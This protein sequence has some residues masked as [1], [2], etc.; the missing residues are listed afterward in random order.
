M[1]AHGGL[2][3]PK[4]FDEVARTS[5]FGGCDHRQQSEARRVG[6]D[7][8]PAGEDRG[9]ARTEWRF[10][11]GFTTALDHLH[12]YILTY[13]YALQ[14]GSR[15]MSE[16]PGD[17]AANGLAPYSHSISVDHTN[18]NAIPTLRLSA[19]HRS[20]SGVDEI[21]PQENLEPGPVQ[22]KDREVFDALTS[23]Y[24]LDLDV[25]SFKWLTERFGL[26]TDDSR[27]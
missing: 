4:W 25:T 10:V 20:R 19:F 23:R 18:S 5:F 14:V 24:Q 27:A 11:D 21:A 16:A 1:V 8:E 9:I 3:D 26:I 17:V 12:V 13:I 15:D 22:V 6:Q 7:L 2:G